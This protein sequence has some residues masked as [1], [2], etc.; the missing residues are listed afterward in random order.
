MGK[1]MKDKKLNKQT[2]NII[3]KVLDSI[4]SIAVLPFAVHGLFDERLDGE[5]LRIYCA[6]F[7]FAFSLSFFFQALRKRNN[8]EPYIWQLI[9]TG[10]YLISVVLIMAVKSSDVSTPI[11]TVMFAGMMITTR[12]LSI[13]REHTY[14]NIF[15]NSSCIILIIV[16]MLWGSFLF[17]CLFMLAADLV[18]IVSLSFSGMDM[19]ILLKVIRKTY[20]VDVVSGLI[21][22]IAAFSVVLPVLEEDIPTYKDALWYCF[23]VVTT[24]GFGD[25]S[26]ATTLGRVISVILGVYGIVVVALVTS[27]VVNFYSEVKSL[28]DDE[29]E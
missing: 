19:K 9:Q 10:I 23:A 2:W 17:V 27:V 13:I 1:V 7:F 21:L 29:E 5:T 22:F 26:T 16:A 15:F 4:S 28:P 25:F 3:F 18:H 24:I 6:A 8:S 20:A 11:I 12:V 14:R